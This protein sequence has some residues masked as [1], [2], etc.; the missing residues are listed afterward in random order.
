MTLKTWI[1]HMGFVSVF[2][3]SYHVT[4]SSH[5]FKNPKLAID[6]VPETLPKIPTFHKIA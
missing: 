6:N 5:F 2:Y 4:E 3:H 1:L